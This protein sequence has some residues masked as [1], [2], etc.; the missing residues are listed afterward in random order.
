VASQG[1]AAGSGI[2]DVSSSVITATLGRLAMVPTMSASV[3]FA[4]TRLSMTMSI[5]SF[6]AA[7]A[8]AAA[9]SFSFSLHRRVRSDVP[10]AI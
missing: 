4:S 6:F 9:A 1:A 3:F 5:F 7:A 2:V 8:F 10:G